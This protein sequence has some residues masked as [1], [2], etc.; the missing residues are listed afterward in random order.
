MAKKNS[1]KTQPDPKI[2]KW[3]IR[4]FIVSII[5]FVI[6]FAN[7]PAGNT[8]QLVVAGAALGPVLFFGTIGW[9]IGKFVKGLYKKVVS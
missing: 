1:K 2:L 5:I 9:F 3:A 4:A 8:E 6:I 7:G